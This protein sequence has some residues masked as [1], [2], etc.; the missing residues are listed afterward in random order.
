[1]VTKDYIASMRV[2]LGRRIHDLREAR[3]LSQYDF[4]KMVPI[5]RSYL[6]GVEKGYRN[7]S[8]EK[9]IM[10]AN[11]LDVSMSELCA[12]IEYASNDADSQE[13]TQ[14]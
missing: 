11:S 5:N 3:G 7:P 10:I 9:I 6:V 8:I 1:M 13:P 12:G 2:N 4:A 14:G